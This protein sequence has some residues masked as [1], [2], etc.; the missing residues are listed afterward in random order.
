MLKDDVNAGLAAISKPDT[1]PKLILDESGSCKVPL[2]F[3][4]SIVK[5][6]GGQLQV[7]IRM[8]KTGEFFT[9]LSP[10]AA[11]H[12]QLSREFLDA[13]LHRQFYA[14]QVSS[15]SFAIAVVGD[16]DLL[17]AVHHWMLDAIAPEE[18]KGLFQKFISAVLSAIPEINNMA[19]SEI[20]L[21]PIHSEQN[22]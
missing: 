20:S 9:L 2:P 16:R 5:L 18:F 15:L 10:L 3:P 13:L 22:S 8:A 11:V 19:S 12:G 6:S 1:S 4:P 21:A 7:E 14:E 17:V